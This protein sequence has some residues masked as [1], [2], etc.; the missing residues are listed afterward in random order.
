MSPK[1]LLRHK[2]AVSALEELSEGKFHTVLAE[3]DKL[4]AKNVRRVIVCSGK[5]YYD[6]IDFRRANNIADMAVIRL[7]QQYPFPHAD[8]E[9]QIVVTECREAVWYRNR[10]TRAWYRRE[11][12]RAGVAA[13]SRYWFTRAARS[14][15]AGGHYASKHLAQ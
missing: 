7:E 13:R 10:R 14:G 11:R 2:A 4:V 5:V 15:I 9:E 12:T 8:F 3:T 6:L 1:S